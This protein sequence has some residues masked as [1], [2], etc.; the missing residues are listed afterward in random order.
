MYSIC[1]VYLNR[2]TMEFAVEKNVKFEDLI[3]NKTNHPW[4]TEKQLEQLQLVMPSAVSLDDL[5]NKFPDNGLV[6]H[7]QPKSQCFRAEKGINQTSP[8]M[9]VLNTLDGKSVPIMR[10]PFG[11]PK[12]Y[13]TRQGHIQTVVFLHFLY[14]LC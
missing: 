12:S 7:A 3:L 8:M 10:A 6:L 9:I 2:N 1:T 5:V 11:D 4:N 13:W 14:L